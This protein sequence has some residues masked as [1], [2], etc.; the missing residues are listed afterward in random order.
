MIRVRRAVAADVPDVA[1]VHVRSWQWAYRGLLAQEYRDGLDP[2][3]WAAGYA[4]GR[5]GFALPTTQVALNGATVCG[6]VT[7]GLCRD[8]DLSNF[9]EV[10][11]IYVDPAYL[12]RGV[13]RSLMNAARN[14][15]RRV[16]VGS[17]ALWVLDGN[18][19]AR[20]CYE[21]D[22]CSCDGARRTSTYGGGAAAE[23]RYRLRLRSGIE[24]A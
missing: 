16:G 15:L 13:G 8:R 17:A 18:V 24:P 14:R 10:M 3:A 9:G 6:L 21:R 7:A 5:V 4:V 1:A 19:A 22:G 20:R 11:A 23:V 2:Q 12:R